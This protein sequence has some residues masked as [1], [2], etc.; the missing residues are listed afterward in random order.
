MTVHHLKSSQPA[1]PTAGSEAVSEAAKDAPPL[2][3]WSL[4]FRNARH[5]L[6]AHILPTLRE[7]G[8]YRSIAAGLVVAATALV[9]TPLAVASLALGLPALIQAALAVVALIGTIAAVEF[10]LTR[11]NKILTGSE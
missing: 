5:F 8:T 9:A 1:Q 6:S 2:P 3:F 11:A 7:A 4:I 10:G